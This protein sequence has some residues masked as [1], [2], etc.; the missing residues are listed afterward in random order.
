[1]S[2]AAPPTTFRL[3]KE[4]ELETVATLHAVIRDAHPISRILYVDSPV[5]R[6]AKWLEAARQSIAEGRECIWLLVRDDTA[7][8]VGQV[9]IEERSKDDPP[10]PQE[11][12]APEGFD[13]EEYAKI[14]GPLIHLFGDLMDRYDGY[15]CESALRQHMRASFVSDMPSLDLDI[16]ELGIVSTDLHLGMGQRMMSHVIDL[17]KKGSTSSQPPLLVSKQSE[18]RFT[19]SLNTLPDRSEGPVLCKLRLQSDWRTHHD[20]SR[21]HDRWRKSIFALRCRQSTQLRYHD[22][23]HHLGHYHAL[24]ALP[25]G[26]AYAEWTSKAAMMSPKSAHTLSCSGCRVSLNSVAACYAKCNG[27]MK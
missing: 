12:T 8:L 7:E 9:W 11:I 10:L 27:D 24:G 14:F 21:Q 25:A 15:I 23:C 19:T 5:D 2:S 18:Y 1:M 17:A 16:R 6:K 3:A 4:E 13:A 26:S 22:R 20:R